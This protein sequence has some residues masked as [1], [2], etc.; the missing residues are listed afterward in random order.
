MFLQYG[1]KGPEIL[2]I[3]WSECAVALILYVF[4][5]ASASRTKGTAIYNLYGIRWD[6]L[7]VSLAIVRILSQRHLT[8][9]TAADTTPL[10]RYVP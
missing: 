2:K 5:A 3:T 4:R 6:F 1:G 8:V 9:P 7:I 10:I